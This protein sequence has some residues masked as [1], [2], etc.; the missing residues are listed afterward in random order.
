MVVNKNI[1]ILMLFDCVR[2]NTVLGSH[3]IC[4]SE[5]KGGIFELMM[6]GADPGGRTR[7]A[8]PPKIGKKYDFLA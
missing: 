7:C 4:N 8:R 5:K 6:A 2:V 3:S 1:S